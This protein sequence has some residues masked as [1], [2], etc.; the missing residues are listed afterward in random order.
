[1]PEKITAAV[2]KKII[3]VALAAENDYSTEV[4]VESLAE[5]SGMSDKYFQRCFRQVMGESPKSYLRRIRLQAAA[6]Y[7]KWSDASIVQLALHYGYNTHGGFTKA[8]R[9]AYGISPQEFREKEGVTPYLS[10]PNRGAEQFDV[11]LLQARQLAVRIEKTSTRRIATMRYVGPTDGMASIWVPML[12]WIKAHNLLN[13]SS[14]LLGIHNDYWDTLAED[15]YRYDAAIVVPDDFEPD[16]AVNTLVLTGGEVAMTEFHG[17]LTEF[18]SHWRRFAEQWFPVSG[19]RHRGQVVYDRYP[20]EL[21]SAGPF[22]QL[23][24]TLT[25]IDATLCLPVTK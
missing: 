2:R 10:S 5:M 12:E 9:K 18:D 21:V 1:M 3:G 4:S 17:S 24:A 6:Y 23:L 19:Y 22:R 16:D 11:E 13:K 7:L 15:R 14:I 20:V 25:G 8:F